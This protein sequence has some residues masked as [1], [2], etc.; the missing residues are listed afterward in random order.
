MKTQKF[1]L[2]LLAVL[3]I[4]AGVFMLGVQFFDWK[5]FWFKGWWTIFIVGAGVALIVKRG[6][7]FGGLFFVF[8]GVSLYLHEQD[9]LLETHMEWL[10]AM[11]ACSMVALGVDL[12]VHVFKGGKLRKIARG[13]ADQMPIGDNRAQYYS[14]DESPRYT[15][16]F[17]G[18]EPRSVC[19]TLK[20]VDATAIFGGLQVD[21]TQADFQQEIVVDI[22][23]LCGGVTII[24]PPHVLLELDG[25]A[26]LGGCDASEITGRIYDPNHPKM[27]IKYFVAF[28][29]IKLK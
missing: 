26:I 12:L 21:L 6:P 20:K 11:I 4:A 8:L 15:A 10:T 1:L 22:L 29:G 3:I 24:T 25:T 23:S 16:I 18:S 19:K 17:G 5:W 2:A 14:T 27:K 7:R 9:I 13:A 28:G